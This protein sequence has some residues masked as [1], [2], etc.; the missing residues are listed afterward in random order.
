M[1]E[2]KNPA[3]DQSAVERAAKA[4][5]RKLRDERRRKLRERKKQLLA[6][7]GIK[8][9]AAMGRAVREQ[10][11]TPPPPWNKRPIAKRYY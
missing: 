10:G 8:A 5:Q 3:E 1:S 9:R 11:S 6:E 2:T 7:E 4:E